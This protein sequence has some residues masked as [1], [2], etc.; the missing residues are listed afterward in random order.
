MSPAALVKRFG[1]K[2]GLL[3]AVVTT[4]VATIP[5]ASLDGIGDP[6]DVLEAQLRDDFVGLEAATSTAHL[7][8][9]LAE[10]ADP[11]IRS[12]VREG[13][14]RQQAVYTALLSAA[15]RQGALRGPA[16]ERAGAMV[17][18][19]AQGVAL[20]WSV[21]PD[22]ALPDAQTAALDILLEGWR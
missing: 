19:L 1:S 16:P 20:R 10:L 21:E 2:R 7:G 15:Q 4:W 8:L 14:R 13:W 3:L 9:L 22:G 11:E 6:L 18:A 17:M 12:L 5:D